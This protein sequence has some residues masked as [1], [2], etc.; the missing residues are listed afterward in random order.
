MSRH[1]VT[2]TPAQLAQLPGPCDA[3][4]FWQ[5]APDSL[6]GKE[7]WARTVLTEWG[8]F[9][10][11]V[12]IDGALVAHI[13][14]AP[15]RYLPR[16]ARLP[17]GPVSDDAVLLAGLR[18]APE[19]RGTGLG[20]LLVQRAA[21]D[22][23]R[24]EVR[25]LEA[26]GTQARLPVSHTGQC[27]VPADFLAAHGFVTVRSR[28]GLS[29]HRLD[30]GAT[31]ARHLDLEP[32]RRRIRALAKGPAAPSAWKRPAAAGGCVREVQQ[33]PAPRPS[34]WVDA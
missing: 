8:T 2:L 28:A 33:A 15:V 16:A 31:E 19:R 7:E 17:A 20:K 26:F 21:A 10:L 12:A 13:L 1:L 22:L 11:G 27:S 25:A 18:V 14:Y 23:L 32:L 5:G 34:R 3:C 6:A 24:R 30:L 29:L 9:G 4:Q